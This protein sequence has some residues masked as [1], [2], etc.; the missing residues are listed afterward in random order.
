ML[1]SC[2]QTTSEEIATHP[3]QTHSQIFSVVTKLNDYGISEYSR[4]IKVN[5]QNFKSDNKNHTSQQVKG[6][7]MTV[8]HI[9]K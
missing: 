8:F 6:I 3:T 4:I 5:N 9:L 2:D 1:S 7:T